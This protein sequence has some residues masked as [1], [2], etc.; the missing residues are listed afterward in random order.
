MRHLDLL[1]LGVYGKRRVEYQRM[2]C[3][4]LVSRM[5]GLAT[6]FYQELLQNHAVPEMIQ[7]TSLDIQSNCP[8]I[9]PTRA[10]RM[11]RNCWKYMFCSNLYWQ[12]DGKMDS[13][14]DH[15]IKALGEWVPT[16]ERHRSSSLLELRENR[17][18]VYADY[19]CG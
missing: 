2:P 16:D 8:A 18:A 3:P 11:G 14:T 4:C 19:G 1:M 5:V 10:L 12:E 13:S 15:N 17:H 7:L 6:G 9:L